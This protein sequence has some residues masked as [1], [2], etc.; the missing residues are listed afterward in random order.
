MPCARLAR[1][2]AAPGAP[3]RTSCACSGSYSQTVARSARRTLRAASPISASTDGRSKGAASLRVTSRICSNAS[4]RSAVATG[5][6]SVPIGFPPRSFLFASRQFA[7]NPAD[8]HAPAPVPPTAVAKPALRS[9]GQKKNPRQVALSGV[10]FE[11]LAVTYSC[12]DEVQTTIGAERFHFRVRKGIGW[13]PLAMAARQTGSRTALARGHEI[14]IWVQR[15]VSQ[16]RAIQVAE[17]L[18]GT[19]QRFGTRFQTDWVLYGQAARAI[20]TG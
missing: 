15:S 2:G 19:R 12:M 20:S 10:L 16:S 17:Q 4:A 18:Q 6:T 3:V 11:S 1:T 5:W 14:Q 7:H 13:F 9:R 8:L